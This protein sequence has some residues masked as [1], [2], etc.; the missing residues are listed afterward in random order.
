MAKVGSFGHEENRILRG[1]RVRSIA[2]GTE[3][4]PTAAFWSAPGAGA[5]GIALCRTNWDALTVAHPVGMAVMVRVDAAR[6][7]VSCLTSGRTT[8]TLFVAPGTGELFAD[9][10]QAEV[11]SGPSAWVALPPSYGVRWDTAPAEDHPLPDA[12]FVRPHLAQVLKLAS[13][14]RVQW[15]PR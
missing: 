11:R 12:G 10:P 15:S 13:A 3:G 14:D 1:K 5:G 9:C 8:A 6:L 4:E 7:H 2:S